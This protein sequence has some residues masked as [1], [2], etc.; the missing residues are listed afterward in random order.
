MHLLRPLRVMSSLMP[1]A[2]WRSRPQNLP[3]P[4]DFLRWKKER[5]VLNLLPKARCP[6]KHRRNYL[7]FNVAATAYVS[8]L[9]PGLSV[10]QPH[11]IYPNV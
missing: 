6:R 5:Y 9:L 2:Y 8:C 1:V 3:I 7:S 10:S 4:A 11:S